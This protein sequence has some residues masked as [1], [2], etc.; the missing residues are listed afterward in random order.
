MCIEFQRNK[1][2]EHNFNIPKSEAPQKDLFK[3]GA[4]GGRDPE[5]GPKNL[6]MVE[7]PRNA[8]RLSGLSYGGVEDTVITI[9]SLSVF[10]HITHLSGK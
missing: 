4:C 5:H 10:A 6:L 9:K 8:R 3:A 7:N 2:G 1:I